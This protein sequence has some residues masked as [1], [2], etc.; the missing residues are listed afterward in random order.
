MLHGICYAFFFAT[1][2]IF[3]DEYFPKDARASAQGLFNL[4]ILGIGVLAAN[5]ICPALRQKCLHDER[6]DRFPQPI[7]GAS[8]GGPVGGGDV[9]V[10]FLA[11]AEIEDAVPRPRL[12][13]WRNSGCLYHRA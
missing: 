3:V 2:Y 5:S 1:V 8:W 10:V 6:R 7:S 12:L 9:D 13:A 4:M 11:A